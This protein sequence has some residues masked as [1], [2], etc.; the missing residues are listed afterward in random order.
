MMLGMAHEQMFEKGRDTVRAQHIYVPDP[1]IG[2]KVV[3]LRERGIFV[4]E[5]GPAIWRGMC[6][7]HAGSGGVI[8]VDGVPDAEG[9][10]PEP[11]KVISTDITDPAELQKAMSEA[12][13]YNG[14]EIYYA[15]PACMGMWM[16]D[17]GVM[18]GLTIISFGEVAQSAPVITATWAR[19]K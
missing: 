4:L 12:W 11:P 19:K 18:H 15:H 3:C 6:C 5:R 14:R 7:T 17:A 2:N 9:F 1:P 8:V 16:L 13:G 10:F